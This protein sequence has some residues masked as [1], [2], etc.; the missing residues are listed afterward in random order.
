MGS[1]AAKPQA[2]GEV[3]SPPFDECG[4]PVHPETAP[5]MPSRLLPITPLQEG[6]P[7]GLL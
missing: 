3:P 4:A 6:Q 1:G 7:S 5:L 2:P